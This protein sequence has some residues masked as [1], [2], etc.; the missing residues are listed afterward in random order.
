MMVTIRADLTWEGKPA[1]AI[2]QQSEQKLK[3]FLKDLTGAT[4]VYIVNWNSW[5]SEEEY[6][7][8]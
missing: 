5:D 2:G 4:D 8:D 3:K 7:E 6:D 1:K